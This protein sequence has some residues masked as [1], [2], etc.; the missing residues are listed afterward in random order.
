LESVYEQLPKQQDFERLDRWCALKASR[1]AP[2]EAVQ[3]QE[4]V[5]ANPEVYWCGM[6]VRVE[7]EEEIVWAKRIYRSEYLRWEKVQDSIDSTRWIGLGVYKQY[8]TGGYKH[9]IT[10][11]VPVGFSPRVGPLAGQLPVVP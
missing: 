2:S 8:N 5:A 4:R 7:K 11:R 3:L 6:F 9:W 1:I 10:Y